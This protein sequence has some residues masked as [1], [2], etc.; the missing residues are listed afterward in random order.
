MVVSP[1]GEAARPRARH[2]SFPREIPRRLISQYTMPGDWVLD[3]FAG[4][5]TTLVEA[6]ALARPFLGIDSDADEVAKGL[7]WLNQ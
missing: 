7:A 6:Q 4:A 3:P 2:G 5:G 1:S